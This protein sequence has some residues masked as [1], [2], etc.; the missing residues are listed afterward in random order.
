MQSTLG[1][2]GFHGKITFTGT[3]PDASGSSAMQSVT[4]DFDNVDTQGQT[5][6]WLVNQVRTAGV[7]LTFDNGAVQIGSASSVTGDGEGKK[8][9]NSLFGT[10]SLTFG[11]A[12][13][14]AVVTEGQNAKF[15]VNGQ[16]VERNTN[17]FELEGI[18]LELTEKSTGPITLT[19]TKDTDKI[20]EGFKSFVE[21][22]NKLIEQLNDRIN[23]SAT[24]KKYALSLIHI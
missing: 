5:V 17:T 22:Y 18:T 10:D 8:I 13:S 16:V 6:E 14:A 9:L 3:Q 24:Y 2:L 7:E 21:D 23:E 20:V 1:E 15:V 12:G 11:T 4:I 19:T